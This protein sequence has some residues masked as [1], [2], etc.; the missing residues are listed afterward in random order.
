MERD[1][2]VRKTGGFPCFIQ[3]ILP[4]YACVNGQSHCFTVRCPL[5]MDMLTQPAFDPAPAVVVG[6]SAFACKLVPAAETVHHKFPHIVTDSGKILDQ[7]LIRHGVPSCSVFLHYTE[8]S[9]ILQVRAEMCNT[10]VMI[11]WFC[12]I[13]VYFWRLTKAATRE[14]SPA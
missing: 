6:A 2:P 1:V 8:F 5:D 10:S 9:G 4:G 13:R 12:E 3:R 7:L 11:V 14:R